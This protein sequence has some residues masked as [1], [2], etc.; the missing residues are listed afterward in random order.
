MGIDGLHHLVLLVDDVPEGERFYQE[1][2]DVDVL[3]REGTLDGEPGTV[4]DDR[5]WPAAQA[6]GVTPYMSFLGRDEF[7]LALAAADDGEDGTGRIDHVALA[8]DD[9]TLDSIAERARAQ[10]CRVEQTAGHHCFVEDDHGVEWEL[11]AGSRPPSRT[12]GELD[13]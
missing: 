13:V 4:P 11:N 10:G 5:S 1:L 9:D 6:A 12:F 3:F 8:V 7:F 2:F